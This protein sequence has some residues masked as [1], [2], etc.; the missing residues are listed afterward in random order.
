MRRKLTKEETQFIIKLQAKEAFTGNRVHEVSGK[1]EEIAQNLA[2]DK[3]VSICGA[4]KNGIFVVLDDYGR[5]F[6]LKD[7]TWEGLE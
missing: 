4:S 6:Q 5:N 7:G 2:K 1:D 3:Y